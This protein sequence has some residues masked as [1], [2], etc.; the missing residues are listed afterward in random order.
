[1]NANKKK[2]QQQLENDTGKK[3]LLRDLTNIATTLKR[4]NSSRNDLDQCVDNLRS[5]HKCSVDICTS[6]NGEDFCGIFVQ[7]DDMRKTFAAFPEIIFLDATYKL[8]ELQFPVYLFSCEESNGATEIVGMGMLVNED[9]ESLRWLIRTFQKKNPEVIN[10]WIVMA[11]KDINE[12]DT[13]K[14]VLPR[15]KAP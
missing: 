15:V 11:D 1:M 4:R 8:L 7:D 9:A 13:I 10:T 3:V 5:V 12:R 2:L 6:E 14:E